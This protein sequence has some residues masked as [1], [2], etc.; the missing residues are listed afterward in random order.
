[1]R[2]SRYSLSAL[3]AAFVLASSSLVPTADAVAQ[4]R[5]LEGLVIFH[6]GDTVHGSIADRDWRVTPEAIRFRPRDSDEILDLT[7]ADIGAFQVRDTWF[8]AHDVVID[9]TPLYAVSHV[10]PSSRQGLAFLEVLVRGPIRLYYHYDHRDHFF[11]DQG[12]GIEELIHHQYVVSR[13]GR[14]FRATDDS[15]R[16]QLREIASS[17]CPQISSRSGY[18]RRAIE[19]FVERCNGTIDPDLIVSSSGRDYSLGLKGYMG[20][21]RMAVADNSIRYDDLVLSP[22]SAFTVGL[23]AY[24]GLP[25]SSGSRAFFVDLK[26]SAVAIGG[27]E[28]FPPYFESSCGPPGNCKWWST[29]YERDEAIVQGWQ[30]SALTGYRYRF[31]RNPVRPFIEVGIGMAML[32]DM[33]ADWYGR[34]VNT[35]YYSDGSTESFEMNRKVQI[36]EF[37]DF[38]PITT[39]NLGL[40]FRGM[41]IGLRKEWS[42][43]PYGAI[44]ASNTTLLL[45]GF[46]L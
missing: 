12:A 27:S 13:D 40:E 5:F 39:A 19:R 21:S 9:E 17:F 25:R 44:F 42:R 24:L 28:R 16:A 46:E 11:V 4:S 36:I 35:Y 26:A 20:A 38:A 31:I 22:E 1:M 15:Y 6:S 45:I 3:L 14:E 34:W 33:Q 29:T 41:S 43:L 37:R 10:L 32:R 30:F 7:P 23:T 18:G 8:E 2:T